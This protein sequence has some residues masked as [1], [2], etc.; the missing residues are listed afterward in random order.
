MNI[1]FRT[2]EVNLEDLL[3]DYPP[4][5]TPNIQTIITSKEEF[6]VLSSTAKEPTPKR[7]EYFKHQQ[8]VQR[9]MFAY[10]KLLLVH[11]PGTGKT[12]AV[13]AVAEFFK[14]MH[15]K[16]ETRFR[17]AYFITP[18]STKNDVKNQIICNCTA[19]EYITPMVLNAN[20]EASRKAN[21]TRELNKWY[22]I[23]SYRKFANSINAPTIKGAG[24]TQRLPPLDN[25]EILRKFNDTII[26][27]DEVHN[28]RGGNPLLTET[29]EQREKEIADIEREE[30]K[31]EKTEAEMLNE[32]YQ[33]LYRI[34]HLVPRCK[35]VLAS[36]TPMINSA[37]EIAPIM[38]LILPE[39]MPF[40]LRNLDKATLDD[41]EPYFRGRV[42]YVRGLETGAVVVYEGEK[43]ESQ[44]YKT[45]TIVYPS[46]MEVYEDFPKPY[47]YQLEGYEN[48]NRKGGDQ[49]FTNE[50]QASNFIFP[51]GSWGGTF[52]RLYKDSK[53]KPFVASGISKYIDSPSS[54]VYYIKDDF[55]P[56]ISN[57]DNM[58]SLS[59]KYAEIIELVSNETNGNCFCYNEFF[60]GCGAILLGM[61]FEGMGYERYELSNSM[62]KSVTTGKLPPL[63]GSKTEEKVREPTIKPKLRY[64]LLTN[65]TTDSKQVSMIEAFNSY[66]NRHGE[67]IKVLIGSPVTRD[68]INL[69][70]TLQ[71]HI[72]SPPWH[73]SGIYQ[74][75]SRAI[76]AT[77]HDAL[78]EEEKQKYIREGKDPNMVKIEIKIYKHVSIPDADLP[79]IDLK[80]YQS[81]E[82]KDRS[83]RRIFRYMK[84]CSV[85]CQI[86]K[87]RN[88]RP[89]DIDGSPEC[90]YQICNYNCV[91]SEPDFI[92]F[93]T[94]DVY[95]SQKDIDMAS[96]D[97]VKL[98]SSVS[99]L[100]ME[101]IYILLPKTQKRFIDM[102]VT[103]LINNK[104]ILYDRYGY[105]VFL[106]EDNGTIF[107]TRDYPLSSGEKEEYPVSYYIDTNVAIEKMSLEQFISYK[108]EPEQDNLIDQLS[109]YNI[110]QPEFNQILNKLNIDTKAKL[111]EQS[112]I[113]VITK[114]ANQFSIDIVESFKQNVEAFKEPTR[115]IEQFKKALIEARSGSRRGRKPKV[116]GTLPQAD[117]IAKQII[118]KVGRDDDG[119]TIYIH[120]LYNK[121]ENLVSYAVEKQLNK[122]EGRLRIW[123]P[124]ENIGWR[125]V[126]PEELPIYNDRIE[127]VLEKQKEPFEKYD[128]Y[129]IVDQNARFIIR[130]KR[131]ETEDTDKRERN[132]GR[133]CKDWAKDDLLDL[134]WK[135]KIN[136]Q[137]YENEITDIDKLREFLI[138][139]HKKRTE[140]FRKYGKDRLQFYY[141]W[142]RLTKEDICPYIYQWFKD[143]QRL[144]DLNK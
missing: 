121:D 88:I 74:A 116:A 54:D 61:C 57:L 94:Y 43:I 134:L 8:F 28:L 62:F 66:E 126:T 65:E 119:E 32:T 36:A 23:E 52:E 125:D 71:V 95:Y 113:R 2:D 11:E 120:N 141:R 3:A 40:P 117:K 59:S 73:Q 69:A 104:E 107:L 124:S 133:N 35:I 29:T 47:V 144:L 89:T 10:D 22:T 137:I 98:F 123:K 87:L 81:A 110:E 58:R 45:E 96:S 135:F 42:S 114:Q 93:T 4:A 39:N 122:A 75:L 112:L 77:S 49:F 13:T 108:Q 86:N 129:G 12:C 7:G 6:R 21:I 63:C 38:N 9:Y 44:E 102:A 19:G 143:N 109:N 55:R 70:N 5:Q 76:R 1:V 25:E 82:N 27:V 68:G 24:G 115:V 50:R 72:V 16:E 132:R 106:K 90:D 26:F 20:T 64:A 67:Y 14:K 140:D 48:S 37:D 83:I 111:L 31:R 142:N 18:K 46:V 17:R 79:S 41:L 131:G 136:P 103:G 127:Q 100:S 30:L 128:I 101:Q 78:I 33:A 34:F 53:K 97:I 15:E 84:Q 60:S 99:S 105:G 80:I 85:D 56:W 91:N 130:D 139:E 92:D 51:D 118:E 138:K